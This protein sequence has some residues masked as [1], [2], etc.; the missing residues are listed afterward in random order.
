MPAKLKGQKALE[1]VQ[2][3]LP[4][5]GVEKRFCSRQTAVCVLALLDRR[6]RTGL[7]AGKRALAEGAR[8]H[9][10]L[11]FARDDLGVRVAEN[12]REAYRK[13]SLRPL[14]ELGIINR[15]QLS[16]ND[17]NTFY[18]LAAALVGPLREVIAGRRRAGD[19]E[20]FRR[21]AK[22]SPTEAEGGPVEVQV[23]STKTFAVSP[24][25]HSRLA[26]AFVEV[27]GPAFHERP[28]AVYIGDTARKSGYQNRE[29]MRELNLPVEIKAGLPDVIL[30]AQGQGRL[31]VCEVV[32]STGSITRSRLAQLRALVGG[33]ERLGHSVEF[34]TAVPSRAVLRRFIEGIAWGTAV[35]VASEPNNLILFQERGGRP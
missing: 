2:A 16:T 20:K 13:A 1:R 6:P 23:S 27:F 35:W 19:L 26:K 31:I 18:R 29:L 9:D 21:E 30:F 34:V 5:L 14:N 33:A 28:A 4:A 3:I 24:G 8:I 10:I 15:H 7:L 11:Q 25:D 17:P 32:T 12:T 22:R